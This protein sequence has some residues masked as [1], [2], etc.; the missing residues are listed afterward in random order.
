MLGEDRRDLQ[1]GAAQAG[2]AA[3]QEHAGVSRA[4]PYRD[5]GD[6][7]RLADREH[8]SGRKRG[9]GQPAM[10]RVNGTGTARGVRRQ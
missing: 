9:R 4:R 8:S 2:L 3:E 5:S 10:S 7:G 6:C 1:L